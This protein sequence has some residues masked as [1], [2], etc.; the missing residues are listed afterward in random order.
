MYAI[1]DIS[2]KQFLVE[3]GAQMDVPRQSVDPGKKVTLDTVLLLDNGK[4]VHVGKP[5][6]KQSSVEVT[7]I[8]HGKT[9]KIPVFKK[10]RRKGYRVK[11]THRQDFTRIRVDTIKQK[12]TTSK[13]PASSKSKTKVTRKTSKPAEGN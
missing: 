9:A 7:V 13:T 4:N 12:K 8:E 5:T 11:N 3:P 1:V 10:K 2:G 6:V